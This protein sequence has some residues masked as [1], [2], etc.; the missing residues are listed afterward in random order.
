MTFLPKLKCSLKKKKEKGLHY[1]SVSDFVIFVSKSICSL[2]K[3]SPLRNSL[4]FYGMDYFKYIWLKNFVMLSRT[5]CVVI[6]DPQG[7]VDP[8]FKNSSLTHESITYS[9]SPL[10]GQ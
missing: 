6:T 4:G 8:S 2:K 3:C 1:K 10:R 5:R 7:S 9:P